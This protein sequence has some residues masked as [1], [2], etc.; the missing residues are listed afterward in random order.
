MYFQDAILALHKFWVRKG[1]VMVQPYDIE[2]G[3]GTFHPTTLLKALGPEP[4]NVAY[5]Q[6]SRRPIRAEEHVP[7]THRTF[8]R[9]KSNLKTPGQ[10]SPCQDD[11]ESVLSTLQGTPEG[12]PCNL[13]QK[14]GDP[15]CSG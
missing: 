8:D 3:A 7:R 13:H 2:V 14:R 4:W 12:L 11:L 15:A 10:D 9:E 6:P 1:C 5:V